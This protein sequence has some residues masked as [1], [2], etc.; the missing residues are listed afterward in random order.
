[1]LAPTPDNVCNSSREAVF[2]FIFSLVLLEFEAESLFV[3]VSDVDLVVSLV[4]QAS[5]TILGQI[6]VLV[7]FS[8]DFVYFSLAFFI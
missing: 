1:M 4:I 6:Q 5:L 7:T 3:F 8:I 2:I